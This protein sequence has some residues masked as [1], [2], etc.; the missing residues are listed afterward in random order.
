MQRNRR[1]C[2]R[3]L[4]AEWREAPVSSSAI[5]S[6]TTVKRIN[7]LHTSRQLPRYAGWPGVAAGVAHGLLYLRSAIW[8]LRGLF[9][10]HACSTFLR[11]RLSPV[12]LQAVYASYWRRGRLNENGH[13]EN[14]NMQAEDMKA[15]PARHK[16]ENIVIGYAPQFVSWRERHLK[17][18][19]C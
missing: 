13:L 19:I 10:L 7:I 18:K 2:M 5:C 16:S 9:Y 12:R 14:R 8:R 1:I 11:L 4:G 15:T 3:V 17:T 6:R